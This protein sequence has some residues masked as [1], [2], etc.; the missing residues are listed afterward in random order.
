[1][2]GYLI[3][4]ATVHDV[5]YLMEIFK[6]SIQGVGRAFYTDE[7]VN[8]WAA[9]SSKR[10][11]FEDWIAKSRTFV[12]VSDSDKPV[13]FAGLEE[14]GRVSSL[15]VHPDCMRQGIASNLLE[16]LIDEARTGQL[17]MMK[18]EASE[19]SRPI[20]ENAGFQVAETEHTT[21]GGVEF[22]RYVMLKNL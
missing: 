1:V 5:P 20:F 10:D 4:L 18:T 2:F 17:S 15:F 19:F 8:A 9:N 11:R 12:A 6:E 3:R 21:I 7:Q 22:S 14:K 16:I 13:G